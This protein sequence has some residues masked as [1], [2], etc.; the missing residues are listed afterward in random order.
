M[1]G[2]CTPLARLK[3]DGIGLVLLFILFMQPLCF[4]LRYSFLFALRLGFGHALHV[5]WHYIWHYIWHGITFGITFGMALHLD[6]V[7]YQYFQAQCAEFRR[8]IPWQSV[9]GT[10]MMFSIRPTSMR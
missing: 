5:A 9:L 8:P 3:N 6:T 2:F 1:G 7:L 10:H 4:Y